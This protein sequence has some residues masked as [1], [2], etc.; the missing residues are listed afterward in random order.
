MR[1]ASIVLSTLIAIAMTAPGCGKSGPCSGG[2]MAKDTRPLGPVLKDN[3]G[4]PSGAVACT[5]QEELSEK[6]YG[7][8]ISF[9]IADN[10]QDGFNKSREHYVA[11]GWAV[12]GN[13]SDDTF[14]TMDL[15]LKGQQM[16]LKCSKKVEDKGWCH[17][18]I[19]KR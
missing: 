14:H 4:I 18:D 16:E 8:S 10:P 15:K 19:A 12:A 7:D 13:R 9:E 5:S 17:V 11:A 3:G 1:T 6:R 2:G